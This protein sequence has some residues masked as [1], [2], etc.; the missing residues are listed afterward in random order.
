MLGNRPR[1][2]R[3]LGRV[4]MRRPLI[5]AYHA[6]SSS[7]PS[8]LAVPETVV[9]V[10]LATL[11]RRGYVGLTF[12]ES[13]RRRL[14]GSLPPR[15]V[16]VT[17]DDAF[18]STLRA[19]HLLDS[20]GYPAT[21]FV[22]T[23]FVDSG[24]PLTFAEKDLL[25]R[26]RFAEELR[27]LAWSDLEALAGS[28]WEIGSHTVSHRSLVK[29]DE[30]GVECELERS[31]AA[32]VRRLGRCDTVAYP[33]GLADER[34]ASVAERVGYLAGCTLT[35]SHVVDSRYL[36][37]RVGLYPTDTGLR[38]LAKL[39]PLV[40]GWLRRTPLADLGL[41]LYLRLANTQEERP[42]KS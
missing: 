33:Y 17:F 6:V 29:L 25:L 19:K 9:A 35:A 28:G 31:R 30:E 15:A 4:Y 13:E 14:E 10:Q 1:F 42:S 21:V 16:V 38:L 20:I 12:A 3:V 8:E 36:R 27:P 5:L 23:D 2:N 32:I 39:S 41:S 22:P 37:A 34:V 7:W 40:G 26:E 18:A 11:H 24:Q